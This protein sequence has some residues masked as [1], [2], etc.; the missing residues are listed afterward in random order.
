MI[1]IWFYSQNG[2]K[3]SN[4]YEVKE[5]YSIPIYSCKKEK[6]LN[7][8]NKFIYRKSELMRNT[9]KETGMITVDEAI[10][11]TKKQYWLEQIWIYN[12]IIG[13]IKIYLWEN[14]IWFDLYLPNKNRIMKFSSKKNLVSLIQLNGVHF[15]LLNDNNEMKSEMKKYLKMAI[16]CVPEKY[17]VNT[18][19][20]DLL[21]NIIDY[22]QLVEKEKD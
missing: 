14:T 3:M 7:D 11:R 1:K 2:V 17:Y 19:E 20:F 22:T 21:N 8:Y 12:Q 9:A 10:D 15:S 5:L 13:Y 6:F 4:N 18:N 16:D